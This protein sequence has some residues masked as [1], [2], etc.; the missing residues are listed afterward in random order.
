MAAPRRSRAQLARDRK[1]IA[2]LYL[3]GFLQHDI[4]EAVGLSQTTVCRDLQT[5]HRQWLAD[6]AEDYKAIIAK[7]LAKIDEMERQYYIGWIRS[8]CEVVKNL[9]WDK[10]AGEWVL[11]VT[12]FPDVREGNPRFLDGVRECINQRMKLIDKLSPEDV[13]PDMIIKVIGGIDLDKDI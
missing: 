11:E 5:L 12:E 10:R 7:Q 4:A 9:T 13:G 2:S 3:Q 6:A 1:L 8:T